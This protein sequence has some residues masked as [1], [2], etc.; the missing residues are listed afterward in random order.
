MFGFQVKVMDLRS[1]K[2]VWKWVRAT[3]TR[4]SD[5]Y[6]YPTCDEAEDMRRMCYGAAHPDLSRVYEVGDDY[7]DFL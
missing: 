2:E 3:G 6:K 5:F 4:P 7:K 1:G